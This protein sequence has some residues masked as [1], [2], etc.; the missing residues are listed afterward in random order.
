MDN[1][2]NR[3]VTGLWLAAFAL[4]GLGVVQV[5]TSSYIFAIESRGDGLYFVKRQFLFAGIAFTLMGAI[6]FTPWRWIERL[7]WLLWPLAG[8]GVALTLIPGLGVRAGGAARWIN[9][10]GANVFEPAELIKVALPLFL[11]T[12]IARRGTWMSNVKPLPRQAL[13]FALLAGPLAL[14]LKQPD[15]GT[16]AIASATIFSVLFVFGLPWVWIVSSAAIAAPAFFVLV[17]Q[18]PYR[19][20][21]VLTFLDPWS[22]SDSKGFQ[23]I[24]SMLSLRTGG[25]TGMG[26][27]E[28]QGKLFFLPE[29]HTDFTLAVL[30]EEMGF[31]GVFLLLSLYGYCL[32]RAFRLASRT[33]DPFRRALATGLASVF[34][35]S[36]F[37]N[38]GVA[39]GLL[40]TKG[41][42]LPFLSYGGSSAVMSGLLFGLLL[43]LE[44]QERFGFT[45]SRASMRDSR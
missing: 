2:Q 39:M 45:S 11:A 17:M 19:R 27:G 43:A 22:V 40:P 21:R 26:L 28:G 36:V 31:I 9:L 10:P 32:L 23:V 15:F 14:V 13:M 41:L 29:A 8:L 3:T 6:A 38:V 1:D 4:L 16:F 12:L 25:L 30:G 44:R 20:A 37:V 18:V 7:G 5:Y 24:Q 33:D 42:T 34:G 35:L